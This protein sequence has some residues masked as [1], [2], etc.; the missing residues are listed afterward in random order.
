MTAKKSILIRK[1][2]TGDA[3]QLIELNRK[4]NGEENTNGDIAV[5]EEE[6]LNARNEIIFVA[7]CGDT[8]VGFACVQIYRSFCYRR[9]ALEITELFVKEEVR[10]RKVATLLIKEVLAFA[11]RENVLEINLRVNKNNQPAIN[12]YRST[13]LDKADHFVFRKKYF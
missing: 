6:L 2:L 10:R 1:A 13:R 12:F 4:H 5:V 11:V 3:A 9:P 8:L 7:V